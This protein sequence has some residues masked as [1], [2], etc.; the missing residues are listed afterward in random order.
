MPTT[1]TD[2]LALQRIVRAVRE[3]A[4]PGMGEFTIREIA[5]A[6]L[7]AA[8]QDAGR[9]QALQLARE[10]GQTDGAHHKA[11]VID[12]MVRALSG[13]EYDQFVREAQ[14]GADGPETYD[15]D[16]GVPP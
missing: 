10:Y 2:D 15:W 7:L 1:M 5:Q 9:E 3:R 8:R 13:I 11:W 12:Q 6:A 16:C 14:A 4:G